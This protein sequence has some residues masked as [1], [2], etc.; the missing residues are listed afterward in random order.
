MKLASAL[1]FALATIAAAQNHQTPLIVLVHGRVSAESDTGMLRREWKSALNA[2]LSDAGHRSLTDADVRLAW[3]ADALDP[4]AE[5]CA[6]LSEE[7]EVLDAFGLLLAAIV[8]SIPRNEARGARTFMSDVMYVL[9]ESRRCAARRRVGAEIERAILTGRPVVVLAYSLGSVVAYQHLQKREPRPRDPPIDLVTMG[10]PLG[11][12]GLRA[13]LGLETDSVRTPRSVRS[14]INIRDAADP[15]AGAIDSS[16]SR[17]GMADVLTRRASGAD[18]HTVERY[19]RD[20]ATAEVVGRLLN[21]NAPGH[22]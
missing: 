13:L 8:G 19:L 12:P 9:D 7:E 18:A 5:G 6:R 20:P 11:I 3:Y 2:A 10:S 1:T 17:P 22:P 21:R 14:W 15:V 4:M 16:G